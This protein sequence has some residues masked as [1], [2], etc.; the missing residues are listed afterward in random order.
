MTENSKKDKTEMCIAPSSPFSQQKKTRQGNEF[1]NENTSLGKYSKL[2]VLGEGGVAKIFKAYDAELD[3][4]VALKVLKR[5]T[6]AP[7]HLQ[8]RFQTEIQA[9]ARLNIPGTIRLF[10]FGKDKEWLY[11]SMELVDGITLKECIKQKKLSLKEKLSIVYKL[12]GIIANIHKNHLCH[13][14]IKPSNVMIDTHNE[15]KLLDFGLVKVLNKNDKNNTRAG[16]IAGSPIYMSP[17]MTIG[18]E[19]NDTK[20]VLSTDVYSLGMLTYEFL[21]FG[22]LPYDIINI[23]TEEIFHCIRTQHPTSIN[24]YLPDLPENLS[25]IIMQ[26]LEKNPKKRISIDKLIKKFDVDIY[27]SKRNSNQWTRLMLFIILGVLAIVLTLNYKKQLYDISEKTKITHNKQ[28]DSEHLTPRIYKN[29]AP[30]EMN[31]HWNNLK[32]KYKDTNNSVLLFS[33]PSNSVL[34]I[35]DYNIDKEWVY[36]SKTL[37]MGVI[38]TLAGTTIELKLD[39]KQMG[40]TIFFKWTTEAGN[41]DTLF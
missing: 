22:E 2:T 33:I 14:D 40:L 23:S 17:E 13:R 9:Q 34:T 31:Y 21:T 6:L 7:E 25:T 36:D 28:K 29:Y 15:V 39:L 30:Q 20:T 18:L 35:K 16:E 19:N 27:T 24:K 32:D 38:T 8:K 3:R 41:V 4:Y 5:G 26:M 1:P 12:Y 37:P 11:Y 10:D